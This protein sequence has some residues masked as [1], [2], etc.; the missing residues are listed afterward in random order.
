M[1]QEQ[2]LKQNMPQ[3]ASDP[4]AL[5]SAMANDDYGQTWRAMYTGA[6]NAANAAAPMTTTSPSGEGGWLSGIGAGM[7]G[8]TQLPKTLTDLEQNIPTQNTNVQNLVNETLGKRGEWLSNYLN[9]I[10]LEESKARRQ[11]GERASLGGIGGS[12]F[13]DAQKAAL[14]QRAAQGRTGAQTAWLSSVLPAASSAD[15]T[16]ISKILGA[17]TAANQAESLAMNRAAAAMGAATGLGGEQ[18]G[19]YNAV[20]SDAERAQLSSNSQAASIL[21]QAGGNIANL[22]GAQAQQF[23]AALGSMG[24]WGLMFTLMTKYP[25]LKA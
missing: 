9:A 22:Y 6:V 4:V 3:F 24:Q 23:M 17:Q 1:S 5:R 8:E 10:D 12:S 2:W 11:I 14:A 15:T 19:T 21:A 13:E 16:A 20:M 18:A 25:N 7:A